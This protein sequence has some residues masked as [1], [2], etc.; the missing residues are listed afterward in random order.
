M[1]AVGDLIKENNISEEKDISPRA[2]Q[3]RL[4]KLNDEVFGFS[5][6]NQDIANRTKLLALNATIESARAGDAGRGFAV[7]ANEVKSLADQASGSAKA[8]EE[9]VVG[10]ISQSMEIAEGLI[11][12]RT[13]D[14]VKSLAHLIVKSL[15]ERVQDLCW[16]TTD[17]CFVNALSQIDDPATLSRAKVRLQNTF[18][19]YP[20]YKEI[21]LIDAQ[22]KVIAN[23]NRNNPNVIGTDVSNFDWFFSVPAQST[24]SQYYMGGIDTNIS[25]CHGATLP[26]SAEVH[27]QEGSA[28]NKIGTLATL[29]DWEK[30]GV[31]FMKEEP[32]FSPS[33]WEKNQILTLDENLK[34]I[35]SSDQNNIGQNYSLKHEGKDHGN[36]KE[37]EKLIA[38]AKTRSFQSF[39]TRDWYIVVQQCI[40]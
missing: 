9:E 25:F 26:I 29:L 2:L 10:R 33:E 34:C 38:F 16:W 39:Q 5:R 24:E 35:A 20:F 22:G 1:S 14:I 15:F 40:K 11:Q 13:L 12:E 6:A 8:F 4:E 27:N 31:F 36:Y 21:V 37:Q 30:M 7:V 32:Q 19:Y 17:D 3:E 23:A 18:D 28:T